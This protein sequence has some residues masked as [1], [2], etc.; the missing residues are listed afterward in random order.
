MKHFPLL[1]GFV[2]LAFG[3]VIGCG[4]S[5][6]PEPAKS[7]DGDSNAIGDGDGDEEA[8]GDGDEMPLGDG[9]RTG[10]T[11]GDGDPV[12]SGGAEPVGTG[13]VGTGGENLG[14]A[15]T[16]GAVEGAVVPFG[17]PCGTPGRLA[18]SDQE[19]K[20]TLI[21]GVSG[22]W[23]ANETCDG[24]QMCEPSEPN[25][26]TCQ[27]PFEPC[28]GRAEGEAYCEGTKNYE[29]NERLLSSTEVS[30]CTIGCLE[31]EC[32]PVADPCLEGT[33][34]TCSSD[35]DGPTSCF[36]TNCSGFVEQGEA[37][38]PDPRIPAAHELCDSEIA[39][40]EFGMPS[41]IRLTVPEW[42]VRL[43][44]PEDWE[45]AVVNYGEFLN[46]EAHCSLPRQTGCVSFENDAQGGGSTVLFYPRRSDAEARNLKFEF[47]E[48]A[49]LPCP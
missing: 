5:S 9:D 36:Y 39:G 20:L 22:I 46:D 48:E 1:S 32:V 8:L 6:D 14:G 4:T 49:S 40:C 13:G 43:P 34:A 2:S 19:L 18:C 29:C 17:A 45:V 21:C 31:G 12:G 25:R 28:Q 33:Y 23:E 10:G 7:G 15:G 47:S 26:G 38:P 42:F 27:L 11:S 37:W 24:E 3:T 41:A 44:I 16:G 35:C 30:D